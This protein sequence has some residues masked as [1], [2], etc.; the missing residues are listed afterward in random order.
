MVSK[1]SCWVIVLTVV[2]QCSCETTKSPPARHQNYATHEKPDDVESPL[3]FN[4]EPVRQVGGFYFVSGTVTNR[5]PHDVMLP[6]WNGEVYATAVSFEVLQ[7]NAWRDV[8]PL[9][10]G[11][12]I[13]KPLQPAASVTFKVELPFALGKLPDTFRLCI[14]DYCSAPV[15]PLQ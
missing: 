7:G 6:H 3:E 4:I 12:L 14:D 9:R 5:T 13:L 11:A 2:S 1:A 15:Y 10:D 8:T